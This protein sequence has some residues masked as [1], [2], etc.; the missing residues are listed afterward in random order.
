VTYPLGD[1]G[2]DTPVVGCHMEDRDDN[3]WVEAC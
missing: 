3:S 1:Q 2:F